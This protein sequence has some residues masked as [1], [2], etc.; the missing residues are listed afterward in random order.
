MAPDDAGQ[1]PSL[2]SCQAMSTFVFQQLA[3][4]SNYSVVQ[5]RATLC[6]MSASKL[7]KTVVNLERRL[8]EVWDGMETCGFV[9]IYPVYPQ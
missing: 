1:F 3:G 8:R 7:E 5:R 2:T 9:W 6:A 4:H